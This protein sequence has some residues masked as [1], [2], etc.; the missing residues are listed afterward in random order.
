MADEIKDVKAEK[1]EFERHS[2]MKLMFGRCSAWQIVNNKAVEVEN[3]FECGGR[4]RGG[5]YTGD[6]FAQAPFWR[7]TTDRFWQY[8]DFTFEGIA[9]ASYLVNAHRFK[10][11]FNPR[12]F[13]DYVYI[14]VAHKD[15]LDP[16]ESTGMDEKKYKEWAEAREKEWNDVIAGKNTNYDKVLNKYGW[17]RG[18]AQALVRCEKNKTWDF[19]TWIEWNNTIVNTPYVAQNCESVWIHEMFHVIW[20]HLARVEERD[21]AQ[22]NIATDFAINQTINFTDEFAAG[23]ITTENKKFFKR[24]IISTVKWLMLTDEDVAKSLKSEYKI[25]PSTDFNKLSDKIVSELHETYMLDNSSGWHKTDKFAN[26]SADL[27]YRILMESCIIVSGAGIAG[28]DGHGKWKDRGEGSGE[29]M[30]ETIEKDGKKFGKGASKGTEKCE[31]KKN[32]KPDFH[33]DHDKQRGKGGREEHKGF[34]PM[35]IAASRSEVKATVKDTLERC[36]INPDDP[37]EIEKAL[38]AT[39]GMN[40]LGALIMEWFKVRRKNW[41]QILKRE[42]VSYANPQDID[43]TMSRESRVI[44]GFF[45]GK[46]RERGLDVIFQV[47][48]SGSINLKDWNDFGN[49]IEEISRSCDIKLVRCLQVHSVIASDEMVNIRRIKNWRIKETGGTTMAL[50]PVKLKKEGNKK[51][52]VIFTDGYIDVFEQKDF[53]FKII[54]FLSRG[55][56]HNA[57]I[58]KERGFT[59]VNQDEE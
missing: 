7:T 32:D 19:K 5:H 12:K 34:D 20:N 24:F 59:V 48:T 55:N 10:L 38:K 33:S 44:E 11:W 52:L 45:P 53:P 58:L 51:L 47:D 57:E 4:G 22:F 3:I 43:Y 39:P 15:N 36:G 50:G 25:T 2:T 26:K 40:I 30:E 35:E 6:K 41:K 9:A 46:K 1:V 31:E 28:F 56:S 54:M 27:Y 8:D 42:L 14:C 37:D 29:G 18:L 16:P 49:Q 23:L 17:D 21:H 13:Y